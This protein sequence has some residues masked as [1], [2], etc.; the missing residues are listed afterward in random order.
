MPLFRLTPLALA[1]LLFSH[2]A[3]AANGTSAA[4]DS[5]TLV[6]SASKQ[7]PASASAKNVSAVKVDA[8]ELEQAGVSRTDQLAKVLP[9]LTMG[10]N[11]SL[12]FQ[13]VSLR[14]IS[15]AADFYNPAV[16]FYVDGVPQLS[17]YAMQAL[18]DV[19][20]VEMLRGPQGTL[21]GR[22]A[23][24]GIVNIVTRK[25]DST[26]RGYV[27]GGI[28]S[29]DGYHGKVN[30]SG[31]LAPDLLYGSVTLL[32]QVDNGAMTN[33]AT[34]SDKLG[35]TRGNLGDLRL[36]LAPD[37]QPWEANVALS[38][39]CTH[40]TQDTY[41]PFGNAHS[42]TL[43]I[44]PGSGDPYLRRCTHSQSL[45]A[46]YRSDDWLFSA[47]SAFQQQNYQR[48]F[49][50][51]SYLASLPERWN[52]DS[53]E[54]R[55]ATTGDGHPLDMVFGLYRQNSRE[56]VDSA[57][58][59]MGYAFS[60]TR[61]WTAS[62]TL[63]AWS[64]LTWH[65]TDRFDLGG[66]LR[67]SHDKAKTDNSGNAMGYGWGSKN[68]T[69]DDN[70]LGQLSAGYQFTPELRGYLRVAQGYKPAGFSIQPTPLVN[71]AAYAAEKSIN[72][73]I[74]TRY[75]SQALELQGALFHTHTKNLQLYSG[76]V[77]YQSLSNA[78]AADA[79]GA[80]L[81]GRWQF[82]PGWSWD[83]NGSWVQSEFTDDSASYPGKRVP[84]VPRFTAG[85]SL[86]GLIDTRWGALMPRVAL[87]L[88]GAHDFDGDNTLHQGSYATTD[89]RLAWQA[90]ERITLSA[91]LNNAF[92]RRYH[93]YG[94]V[95]SGAAYGQVNNG[96]TAGLDARID[97]F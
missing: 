21:Y 70:L 9:G 89:L 71:S 76:P 75:A 41:L 40:A 16:S 4:F 91:Y 64:D 54:L 32:R 97:L 7:S 57:Y 93:T 46:Q 29:R 87:N 10:N 59:Q 58:S 84:F 56:F 35:G 43:E 86:N 44:A 24:G 20:S 55:A 66:G 39:E 80:E 27:E 3:L 22:S 5:E 82:T 79:S 69:R 33:P 13:S 68:H 73:E 88:V 36:R 14:G 1:S 83:A 2:G 81:S 53:Q 50:Y 18:A 48:E 60:S 47:I 31:P 45:S 37:G 62:E 61:S 52:Q 65:L 67:Y 96:R 8:A 12:I 74:G 51:A 95:Q 34:G 94:V 30:L 63:A 90:S 78:G 19:E 77:G 15:S 11:G 38:E 17:T 49:P 72:Y 92:D 28:A 25:P 23:Q 42:R 6:V 26:P 85:T